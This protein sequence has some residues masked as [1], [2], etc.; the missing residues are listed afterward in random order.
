LFAYLEAWIDQLK[1][2]ETVLKNIMYHETDKREV[3]EYEYKKL[4]HECITHTEL[5]EASYR[6]LVNC[7]KSL[8]KLNEDCK[9]LRG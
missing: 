5:H 6:D 1:A 4:S 8:Q 3:L 2:S 7:Y 9:K